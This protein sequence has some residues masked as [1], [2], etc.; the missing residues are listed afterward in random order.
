MLAMMWLALEV[1]GCGGEQS[2]V[3]P[4]G[5]ELPAS[6]TVPPGTTTGVQSTVHGFLVDTAFRP[7]ADARIEAGD[8][9]QASASSTS[10]SDGR[11]V[12]TGPF[13][14]TTPFRATKAGYLEATRTLQTSSPTGSPFVIFY[15]QPVGP[16]ANIAGEYDVT[17][18]VDSTCA[19][20]PPESLTR[21]HVAT[22]ARR[23]DP[24]IPASS[25]FT[26][27]VDG[28]S[29][30]IRQSFSPIGVAG[31]DLGFDLSQNHDGRPTFVEQLASNTYLAFLPTDG[32]AAT[33]VSA[34]GG[35][36]STTFDGVVEYC[37][38]KGE[39]E[40]AYDCSPA[41]AVTRVRCES[42]R[43]GIAFTRR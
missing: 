43:H 29:P 22:I 20:L 5:P 19:D 2:P 6:V 34:G 35:K 12:L 26:V 40:G 38:V 32:L 3:A 28:A 37:V 30:G 25:Y 23:T 41:R 39:M 7:L 18:A 15:L 1:A 36:F 24:N 10:D 27:T 13:D 16:P 17:L 33:T 31:A 9:P 14:R 21:S 42:P 4:T 11:F 8:G